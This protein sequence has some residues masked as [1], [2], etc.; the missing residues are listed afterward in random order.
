[1]LVETWAPMFAVSLGI[2]RTQMV[3]LSVPQMVDHVDYWAET[4]KGAD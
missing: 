1:V 3:E 4:T 2:P